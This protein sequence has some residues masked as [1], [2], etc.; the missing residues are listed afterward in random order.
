MA[1]GVIQVNED[2]APGTFQMDGSST[3]FTTQMKYG[4]GKVIPRTGIVETN[5]LC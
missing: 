3:N 2:H 1:L 5:I 4:T